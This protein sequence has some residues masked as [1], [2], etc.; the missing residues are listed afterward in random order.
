[1]ALSARPPALAVL[2]PPVRLALLGTPRSG[3]T[4]FRLLVA[5]ACGVAEFARHA[6]DDFPW[7]RLPDEFILQLHARPRPELCERL[8]RYGIRPVALA[9]HPLDV[10]LSILRY[11]APE[12]ESARWLDGEGGDESGLFGAVPVDAAFARY[13]VGPRADALLSLTPDWCAVPECARVH[14]ERLVRDPEGTLGELLGESVDPNRIAGAV[15]ARTLA[16]VRRA[17]GEQHVWQGRPGLWRELLPPATAA[18]IVRHHARVMGSLGYAY[19]P[20]PALTDAVARAR[21]AALAP[22]PRTVVATD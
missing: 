14:Y 15:R 21:W 2:R 17:I 11:A 22:R 8:A 10:L 13:A 4:W 1:M 7:E 5:D 19:D 6:I 9:R 3:S 18:P 20:D 12:M 16:A